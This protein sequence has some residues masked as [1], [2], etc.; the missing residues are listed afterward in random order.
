LFAVHKI[1]SEYIERI[2]AYIEKMPRDTKLL[3][4]II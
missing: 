1:I 4:I 3:I 2:Y